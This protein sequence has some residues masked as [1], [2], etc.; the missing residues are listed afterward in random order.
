MSDTEHHAEHEER[1]ALSLEAIAAIAAIIGSALALGTSLFAVVGVGYVVV[2]RVGAL[3]KWRDDH[4][5]EMK[6]LAEKSEGR[7]GKL[8]DQLRALEK[9]HG[10][11]IL[12]LEDQYREI[13]GLLVEIK[14]SL[15][16]QGP[17]RPAKYVHP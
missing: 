6:A 12:T 3:E 2:Y 15:A 17:V 10:D 7:S 13:K 16:E 14:Q 9:G 1:S 5:V 8:D 11:R 4:V